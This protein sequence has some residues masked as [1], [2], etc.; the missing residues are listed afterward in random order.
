MA[1]TVERR[2]FREVYEEHCGRN[3]ARAARIL[4]VSQQT[5]M[6]M[7]RSMGFPAGAPG[8]MRMA[9]SMGFP[10]GAPGF[11]AAG[12]AQP[13]REA[14]RRGARERVRK[15]RAGLLPPPRPRGKAAVKDVR[16]PRAVRYR[17]PVCLAVVPALPHCNVPSPDAE[18]TP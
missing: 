1:R 14:L 10:A 6:R 8:V 16:G 4:G 11:G 5:V 17:C 3:A 18:T 2:R 13:S 12:V 9:R 7:A 15:Q